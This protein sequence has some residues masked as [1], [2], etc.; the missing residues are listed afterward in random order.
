[1]KA[2]EFVKSKMPKAKIERQE[3]IGG[4]AYYL[5]RDGLATMWF[6]EGES[7]KLAWEN[8]K[9]RIEKIDTIKI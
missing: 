8:A 2:E 6:A 4:S 9:K 5:I 1:M 3:T 7:K